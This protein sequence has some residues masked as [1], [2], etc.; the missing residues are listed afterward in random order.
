M[1]MNGHDLWKKIIAKHGVDRCP[2]VD[3]QALWA[4]GEL[5]ELAQAIQKAEFAGRDPGSDPAVRKEYADA[6]LSLYGLGVKLG[7]DLIEE[8]QAVVDGETRTFQT[9]V[10]PRQE[11]L[12][13]PK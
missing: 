3:G 8:M 6:G 12:P 11:T 5:G 1:N 2:A 7:L 13:W 4:C 10:H 9:T